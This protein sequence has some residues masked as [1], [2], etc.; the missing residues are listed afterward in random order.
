MRIAALYDIHGNLPA[1]AAVLDELAE[2]QPDVIVLGGD[3]VSGPLPAQT[4]ARLCK[5]GTR[6]LA[7]RGNADR[8]VVAAFDGRPPTQHLPAEVHAITSWTA[9]QL[10]SEQRDFLA[11]LPAHVTM[12]VEGLGDVLFCHATPQ[13]DEVIF[14]PRTSQERLHTLFQG[15]EQQVV[16]CGHTHMQFELQVGDV[17]VLNAGSVGMPYAD[18]PGAYWLLLEPGSSEFRR[19]AYDLEAAARAVRSSG[20]PQAHQ[21]AAENLLTVPGAQEALQVF[22]Q[23]AEQSA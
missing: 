18:Q 16:V 2:V 17:R 19:T 12:T 6:V 14:T 4:L 9:Q 20:Y 22:E 3:I 8:E 15:L 5:A 11:G 1:L 10:S 23:M 13:S 21:F 7:I